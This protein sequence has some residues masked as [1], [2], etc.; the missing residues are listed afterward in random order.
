MFAIDLPMPLNLQVATSYDTGFLIALS[1]FSSYA[2]RNR[3][4]GK[5]HVLDT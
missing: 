4:S 3:I 2:F 1:V 5:S